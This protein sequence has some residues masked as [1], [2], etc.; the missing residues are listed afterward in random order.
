MF[1]PLTTHLQKFSKPNE[2]E[3]TSFH[4]LFSLQKVN[5]KDHILKSGQYAKHLY[6]VNK[7]CFR[8]YYINGKGVEKILTFAIEGW[9]LGDFDSMVN[10]RPTRLSIQALEDS[11]LLKISKDDLEVVLDSSLE[12]NKYFRR[13]QEKVRIAD[14]RKMQYFSDLSGR[15][16][17]EKFTQA[18]PF[19]I[20]RIPQYM[21][22]SYL[23]MTPEF[24]SKIRAEELNERS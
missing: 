21:L 23:D 5:K 11:E 14:Q 19:F 8:L 6:F 15:E 24:L 16:L 1:D 18:N 20:Q 4:S 2:E 22:A 13:I 3:L 9:W 7:G 10:D 17:Y 12:L